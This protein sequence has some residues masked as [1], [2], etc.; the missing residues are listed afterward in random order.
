VRLPTF[1]TFRMT[2]A[3]YLAFQSVGSTFVNGALT[4]LSALPARSREVIPFGGADGIV[5]DTYL[6]SLLLS[7]LTVIVGSLFV[8]LDVKTRRVEPHALAPR[9]HGWFRW[10]AHH[11]IARALVSAAF[12]TVLCAPPTLFVLARAGFETMSFHDFLVFKVAYAVVLGAIVT[13]INAAAVLIR[14][15]DARSRTPGGATSPPSS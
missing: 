9:R 3:Q 2:F 4:A 1:L 15:G 7:G 8:A 11:L 12:F 6:T 5:R 13:P 10:L 14:K